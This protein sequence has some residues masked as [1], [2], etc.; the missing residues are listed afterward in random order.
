MK[1]RSFLKGIAATVPGI[2]TFRLPAFGQI[3]NGNGAQGKY[4]PANILNEYTAFLPG[5]QEALNQKIDVSRIVMQYQT[6]DASAGG[7]QKTLR[8]GETIQGWK[9]L[10]V[11]P[12]HNGMPTAVFE[13]NVTHQGTLLF[14]NAERELA[15]V[16]KQIGDLSKIRPRQIASAPGMKFEDRKSTRLNFSHRP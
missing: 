7:E 3:A 4:T 2:A 11:L 8:I 1:R 5:E 14:I 16:P 6:V 15:R 12:W 10:S 13:K 9:L